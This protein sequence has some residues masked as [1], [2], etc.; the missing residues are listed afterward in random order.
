MADPVR[1]YAMDSCPSFHS[2]PHKEYMNI[3]FQ[4]ADDLSYSYKKFYIVSGLGS[5]LSCQTNDSVGDTK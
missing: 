1:Q 3:L 2:F 5:I 4:I